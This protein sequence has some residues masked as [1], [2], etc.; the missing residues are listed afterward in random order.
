V[1][2]L[3]FHVFL[4]LINI[5]VLLI[6]LM[7]MALPSLDLAA[8]FEEFGFTVK[9]LGQIGLVVILMAGWGMLV[10]ITPPNIFSSHPGFNICRVP[11]RTRRLDSKPG[12]IAGS[13][14]IN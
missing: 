6:G 2:Q 14:R 9:N 5:P 12:G 7:L 1:E 8:G 10:T 11:G 4:F 13:R 3:I